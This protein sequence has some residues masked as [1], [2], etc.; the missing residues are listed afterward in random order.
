MHHMFS[1]C[2]DL[3]HIDVSKWDTSNVTSF[4]S[5]FNHC[6]SLTELDLTSFN[7]P[8]I[9]SV[10]YMFR[11]CTNLQVAK[12]SSKWSTSGADKTDWFE[13]AGCTGVTRV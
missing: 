3:E 4:G 5:M 11:N 13:G 12:I 8:N 9:T 2:A 1:G 7:T 10:M 6:E